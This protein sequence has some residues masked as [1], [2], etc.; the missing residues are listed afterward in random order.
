MKI[1]QNIKLS[2]IVPVY[3]VAPFLRDCLD[4]LL[5]GIAP[6]TEIL[7]IDD[8]STDGSPEICDEY[9]CNNPQIKVFHQQNAGHSAAR[10]KGLENAEGSF[11]IFVD[12]DDFVSMQRVN[13]VVAKMEETQSDMAITDYSFINSLMRFSKNEMNDGNNH[14]FQIIGVSDY[15]KNIQKHTMMV[16]NKVYRREVVKDIFYPVGAI[17]EDVYYIHRV[18]TRVNKL[19]YFPTCTYFYRVQR[20]GSTV[21]S[22]KLN[23]LKGYPYL[24]EFGEY[25][26]QKYGKEEYKSVALYI[27]DF[28]QGQYYECHLLLGDKKIMAYILSMYRKYIRETPFHL[29][30]LYRSVFRFSPRLY[31]F[32]RSIKKRHE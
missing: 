12:S 2:A 26:F 25:V 16:W 10:N 28:F 31:L 22:F 15:L 4:S 9:A 32:I 7:I 19:L 23:R 11:L 21:C 14:L 29:F 5:Y 17:Y 13:H 30:P 1:K 6:D 3:N 24:D 20:E 18:L 27:A 8:G